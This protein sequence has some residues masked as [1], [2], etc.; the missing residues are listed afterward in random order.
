MKTIY[1][2]PGLGA[3]ETI[4]SKL[5]PRL[6]EI[7]PLKMPRPAPDESIS[8]YAGRLAVQIDTSRPFWLLG[9]SFGGMLAIE[10]AGRCQTERLIL[11]SSA[12]S[13]DELPWYGR[14]IGNLRLHRLVPLSQPRFISPVSKFLN[15]IKSAEDLAVLRGFAVG[16]DVELLRWSTDQAIRW[17]GG[18]APANMVC[19]H[20][21]ADRLI[22][23]RNVHAD[24]WIESGTHFMIVTRGQEI[25]DLIDNLIAGESGLRS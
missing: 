23:A 18:A 25:S 7:K 11:V 8:S 6:A 15:G 10:L 20:G 24:Y 2:I 9:Q 13:R 14:L 5:N 16:R 22:P 1:C 17:R 21:T 3:N 19:I 4:F 12:R